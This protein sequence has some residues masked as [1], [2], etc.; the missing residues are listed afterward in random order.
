M[1]PQH[2]FSGRVVAN[3]PLVASGGIYLNSTLF[4]EQSL[5]G[6]QASIAALQPQ[7]CAPP[8]GTLSFLNGSWSCSCSMGWYGPSC[9]S[10]YIV[11]FFN[12]TQG[13]S[14]PSQYAVSAQVA[15]AFDSSGTMYIPDASSC[16][17]S[18]SPTGAVSV[19]AGQC[20]NGGHADG[21]ASTAQF[22]SVRGIA[23]NA[24]KT[25]MYVADS[26]SDPYGTLYSYVRKIANGV[27]STLAGTP[28][29]N[30]YSTGPCGGSSRDGPG[31]QAIFGLFAGF[32]GGGANSNIISVDMYDNVFIADPMN[33]KIR[34]ISPNG[35]VSTL[36]GGLGAVS[37]GNGCFATPPGFLD[38]R[39]TSAS[40]NTPTSLAFDA[41][42]N[43][44]FGE[45]G[46]PCIRKIDTTGLVTSVAGSCIQPFYAGL[47]TS[48]SSGS[49]PAGKL[50]GLLATAS[51]GSVNSITFGSDGTLYFID[52][53]GLRSISPQGVVSTLVI[54]FGSLGPA[55]TATSVD[56]VPLFLAIWNSTI[57]VVAN[58]Y[59][60]GW[61]LLT[62]QIGGGVASTP[63]TSSA[64]YNRLRAAGLV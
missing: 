25:T 26:N 12:T 17:K 2:V 41:V 46:N 27:V 63:F 18:V 55:A 39:G 53:N 13:F 16:I 14:N 48:S 15:A 5:L 56:R 32:G 37:R 57:F 43:L 33:H 62:I 52:S 30:W 59:A 49:P 61:S 51:L 50:D 4:N 44:F 31:S 1:T 20:G 35:T 28:V 34:M 7:T 22:Y 47:Y 23:F 54:N 36:A 40:L 6:Q 9:T 58:T 10:Q 60:Y 19:F 24:N 8:S 11:N 64:S 42:G 21:P 38:G 45:A 29:T 3:T